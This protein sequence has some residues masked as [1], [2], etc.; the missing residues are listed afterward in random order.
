MHMDAAW[1]HWSNSGTLLL[2][3]NFGQ[4]LPPLWP[5]MF[6]VK[7][8]PSKFTVHLFLNMSKVLHRVAQMAE[9]VWCLSHGVHH[10]SSSLKSGILLGHQSKG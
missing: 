6:T 4:D 3:A 5:C 2:S 8:M 10:P 9:P 7:I 1:S